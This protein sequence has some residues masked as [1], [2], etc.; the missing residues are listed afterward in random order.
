MTPLSWPPKIIVGSK[1]ICESTLHTP[2][3]C[4]PMGYSALECYSG[5]EW[6]LKP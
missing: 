1:D 3:H 2:K 6:Q 4:D 5:R